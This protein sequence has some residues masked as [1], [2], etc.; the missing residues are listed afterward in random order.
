[1]PCRETEDR[2]LQAENRCLELGFQC[3][4]HELTRARLERRLDMLCDGMEEEVCEKCQQIAH[5]GL[6]STQ[7][8][9]HARVVT[10]LPSIQCG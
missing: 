8:N 2:L 7:S 6:D 10:C 4:Q 3:E 9:N 1:M 5:L